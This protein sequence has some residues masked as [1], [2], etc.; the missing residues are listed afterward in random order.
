M[1]YVI[2]GA[3]TGLGR[4]LA[5]KFASENNDLI[6]ISSDLRDLDAL[7]H[8]LQNRFEVKIHP[9]QMSFREYPMDFQN[10]DNVIDDV[11]SILGIMLPIGFSDPAD[12]PSIDKNKMMEI[13]NINLIC[14][15]I[16]INR[17]L[18]I[19]RKNKSAIIGFGSI[20]A[21]RGRTRNSTYAAAKRGLESYFES[22]R[23]FMS[24]ESVTVQFYMLGYL[25]TNLTFGEKT[26]GFKPVN[27]NTLATKVYD[28]RFKDFGKKIYPIYWKPVEIIL[29]F[30][31]WPLFKKIKF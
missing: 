16:F 6:I 8:D 1:T 31:P 23:H 5:E 19:L 12:N 21:I 2:V 3:S 7:K 29:R 22:L 27:V 30:L 9:I 13:F 15:C 24:E 18:E 10:L 4:A 26:I 11:G 20:A 28:N 25:D 14:V 17:Y